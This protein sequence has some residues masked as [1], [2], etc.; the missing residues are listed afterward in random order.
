MTPHLHKKFPFLGL[1]KPP[2]S[3]MNKPEIELGTTQ[4]TFAR[5]QEGNHQLYKPTRN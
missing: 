1:P 2:K 4:T 3:I 5:G